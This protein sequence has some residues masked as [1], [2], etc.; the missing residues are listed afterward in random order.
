[1]NVFLQISDNLAIIRA[2]AEST[3]DGE[4]CVGDYVEEVRPCG[5]FGGVTYEQLRTLGSGEYTL[6]GLLAHAEK[7]L[8]PAA[9]KTACDA[10]EKSGWPYEPRGRSRDGS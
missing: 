2:L 9:E 3:V 5:N 6:D 7:S 10:R 1:M 4:I 8:A